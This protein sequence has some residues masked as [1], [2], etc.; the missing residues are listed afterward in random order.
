[1]SN[2]TLFVLTPLLL[3]S[4]PLPPPAF[5]PPSLP[6]TMSGMRA[7]TSL[8]LRSNKLTECP[9]VALQLAKLATLDL[10]NNSIASCDALGRPQQ[11]RSQ[12]DAGAVTTAATPLSDATTLVF[13][14]LNPVCMVG[15]GGGDATEATAVV[16]RH[17]LGAT[18]SGGG[19]VIQFGSRW[20]AT[21]TYN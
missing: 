5:P 14:R 13:L 9:A 3:P 10:R 1:M 12:D 4:P 8:N 6:L 21:C 18:G 20:N 17:V 15:S 19:G 7:L 11:P 16:P 2:A